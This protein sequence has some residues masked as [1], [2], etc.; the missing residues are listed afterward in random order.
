MNGCMKILLAERL[1]KEK[2]YNIVDLCVIVALRERIQ[3]INNK[4]QHFTQEEIARELQ[5][6][7]SNVCRSLK[8]LERNNV[9]YK[10]EKDY[11]FNSDYIFTL[12]LPKPKHDI[13]FL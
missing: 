7:Q 9:I 5:Y 8:R 11:Y 4:I 13:T 10:D 3:D 2:K 6:S 1:I 12:D